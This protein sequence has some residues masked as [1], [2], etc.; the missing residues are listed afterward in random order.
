VTT[1]HC[2][3]LTI[4][5]RCFVDPDRD[6]S[7]VHR[8]DLAG[9]VTAYHGAGQARMAHRAGLSRWESAFGDAYVGIALAFSLPISVRYDWPTV[10]VAFWQRQCD[11]QSPVLLAVSGPDM[12]TVPRI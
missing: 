4:T 1:T 7:V 6:T 3:A 11:R 9:R 12:G 2:P 8:V 5:A 10:L